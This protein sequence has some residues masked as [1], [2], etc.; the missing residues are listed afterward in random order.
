MLYP[1]VTVFSRAYTVMWILSLNVYL[2][3][4]ISL[5]EFRRLEAFWRG[6]VRISVYLI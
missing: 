1:S 5:H 3:F 4:M 2:F 6:Y